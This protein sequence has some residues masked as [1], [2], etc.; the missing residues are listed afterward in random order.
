MEVCIGKVHNKPVMLEV[1][2]G[3]VY[4]D[5]EAQP[6]K[7]LTEENLRAFQADLDSIP[8]SENEGYEA[9]Q[10]AIRSAFLAKLLGSAVGDQ[11]IGRLTD[12]LDHVHYNV[13]K[14]LGE[15]EEADSPTA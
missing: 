2:N 7:N 11:C 8:P 14:Y 6:I 4:I 5:G 9:L 12:I 1:R 10:N 3:I 15:A 13:L